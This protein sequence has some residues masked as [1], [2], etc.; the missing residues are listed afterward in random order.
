MLVRVPSVLAVFLFVAS[1]A[2]SEGPPPKPADEARKDLQQMQGT[3][4]LESLE[5]G[6]KA[7]VDLK[8]RTLFIGGELFLVR[9]GDRVVQAGVLRLVASRSPRRIDVA[10][11]KGQ[12]EDGTMLGIYEVKGDTLKVCFDP[13]GEGRPDKFATKPDT[14]R[15]VAVYKRVKPAGEDI[16]IRGKYTSESFG[17]DGK[18]Q[19]LSAAIE[20]RGDAY[21]VR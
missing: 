20:K 18:K 6:K 8:K 3:W 16:D 1:E 5:D 17:A 10:V 15:F 19:S 4:Q 2:R 7:K 12:N 11:R 14:P 9:D 13:E 21:L